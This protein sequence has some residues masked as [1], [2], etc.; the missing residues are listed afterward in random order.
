MKLTDTVIKSFP[1]PDKGNR[2]VYDDALKG[3]GVRVT[4]K[5][6]KAFVLNYRANGLERRMTIGK[7]PDWSLKT[8]RAEAARYKREVDRGND[9]L[10]DRQVARAAV[11]VGDFADEFVSDHL[12][13]RRPATRSSY[14]AIINDHIKPALKSR[15]VADV[16]Y[17]DVAALHRKITR[18]GTPSAAN[19]TLAV[20]SKIFSEAV[21]LGIVATNP[22]KGIE[23]NDETK[24]ERFLTIAELDRLLDALA[25]DEDR[26]AANIFRLILLT[27]SRKTEVL[28]ATWPMFDLS[29]GTWTKP[30][31][32]TKQK[33]AH[34]IPLSAPASQLLSEIRAAAGTDAGEYVFP[35]HRRS[36]KLGVVHLPYRSNVK[37][38]WARVTKAAALED[39]HIHDLR[40]S[41]ASFLVAEGLS[42]PLIGKLLGHTQAATTHRYAHIDIDPLRKATA[43]VGNIVSSRRKVAL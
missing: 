38:A 27:G 3:F 12:P 24:R 42:L 39:L 30:S 4:A 23:K 15:P 21:K 32:H 29:A 20:L 8:A 10:E 33:R 43:H 1:A 28:A 22:V 18:A 6:K 2:I 41:Y 11:T 5:G 34:H 31:H 7:F 26:Q 14:S 16:S 9:P 13:K 40:H 17:A 37:G 35:V 19:R 36:G 25:A